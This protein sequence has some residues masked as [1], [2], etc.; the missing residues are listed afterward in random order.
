MVIIEVTRGIIIKLQS[1][2]MSDAKDSY[3]Y[4]ELLPLVSYPLP[5]FP[6]HLSSHG[7]ALLL[8]LVDIL[9]QLLK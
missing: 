5:L 3:E 8:R 6:L 2:I 1:T 9:S 7:L 4:V